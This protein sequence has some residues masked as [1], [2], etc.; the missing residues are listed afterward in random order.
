[1]YANTIYDTEKKNLHMYLDMEVAEDATFHATMRSVI[2]LTRELQKTGSLVSRSGANIPVDVLYLTYQGMLGVIAYPVLSD[3]IV[4]Y[5]G[6]RYTVG[7]RVTF[8]ESTALC[9]KMNITDNP[10]RCEKT[11][12]RMI[13]DYNDTV[14]DDKIIWAAVLR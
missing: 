14:A 6:L 7:H 12:E 3:A 10:F 2:E 8:R 1:M 11:F 4:E 9:M 13:S 5:R